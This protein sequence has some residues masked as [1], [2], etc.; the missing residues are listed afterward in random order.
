MKKGMAFVLSLICVLG[1]AGCADGG[2]TDG[3]P[4]TGEIHGQ[5]A[6]D[7]ENADSVILQNIAEEMDAFRYPEG[8]PG[9]KTSGFVNTAETEITSENVAEHAGKECTIE[10]DSVTTVLDLS[11]GV[12]KVHFY[13]SGTAGGDQTVY[14]DDEGKTILIVYGE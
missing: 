8:Q 11:K 10:Y 1:M 4:E 7:G 3:R 9:V 6:G 13:T 14:L 5:E 12:W 2:R